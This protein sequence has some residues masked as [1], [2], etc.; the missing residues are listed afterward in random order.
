MKTT[1]NDKGEEVTEEVWEDS[2]QPS[3]SPE[4]QKAVPEQPQRHR[5]ASEQVQ[6]APSNSPEK[7]QQDDALKEQP[8]DFIIGK[9]VMH[10]P[11]SAQN[12]AIL[13]LRQCSMHVP[14]LMLMSCAAIACIGHFQGCI[15]TRM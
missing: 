1:I 7:S 14:S 9:D 5:A 3:P 12:I 4:P 13:G 11:D 2:Q 6:E 8:G 10:H 15:T